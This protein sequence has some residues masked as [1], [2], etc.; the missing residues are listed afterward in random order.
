[1]PGRPAVAGSGTLPS[2]WV[3][4]DA[5]TSLQRDAAVS[6]GPGG[7][8]DQYWESCIILRAG[9][10]L[11]IHRLINES[12]RLKVKSAFTL[13]LLLAAIIA[14]S[15]P[16][17]G[18]RKAYLRAA[19]I[20]PFDAVIIP[21]IPY[22]GQGWDSVMKSRV[23]WSY[24]LYR[25]GYVKN[26]IYSGSAVYTP[27]YEA[28]VMALYG[29]ALG[30]PRKN[31]YCDTVAKHSTENVYYS[32]LLAKKKGFKSIALAT[33]PFQS[34]M[35][36]GFTRKRFGSPIY[37][38]PFMVDSLAAYNGLNPVIDASSAK[39]ANWESIKERQG[40]G[41]RMRGTLGKSINWKAH[42][43]GKVAPL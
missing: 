7:R 41:A 20:I 15:V 25:N 24:I 21:G 29:Q 6:M 26:V 37:H 5:W 34:F 32:Y 27:Y 23:L 11:L 19:G 30:I 2:V 1:M 13:L 12:I 38:I 9:I 36:R 39:V 18:A 43:G 10:V 28:K 33:D 4:A 42:K 14:C 31:I 40:F 3:Q 8:L 35:L 16:R 17:K 22:N